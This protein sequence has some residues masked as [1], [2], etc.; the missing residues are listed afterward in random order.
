[1]NDAID[2][3]W[4]RAQF[5][6]FSVPVNADQSFFENAG[7]SFACRQT[8]DAL[9]TYYVETKVQPYAD[10]G[11]STRA[12]DE[13]DRSRLRWAASL[14]V[15]TNEV[16]F[17]P[18]TSMN[19][20]VLAD[21]FGQVMGP[22]DELI[23]TNQ[24]HEA[25]TGVF[26]RMA[27]RR[28]LTMHEWRTDPHT[29]LLD[30]DQLSSLLNSRTRLVTV[31]HASNIIGQENDIVGITELAH[32]A[33]AR[34]IV[35]G[36]SFVPHTIPNVSALG[37]DVYLFSMYKTYSVHQGLMVVRNGLLD[38]LP[39]QG[40]FFN[41][42]DASKRLSPAGPDHAQV[43]SS[44]AVLDYIGAFHREHGG[45]DDSPRDACAEASRRWRL[46]ENR[47]SAQLLALLDARDDVRVIGPTTVDGHFHRCP[48]ISFSPLA[49][50]PVDVARE[51]CKRGVQT[52]AGD[53]YAV[54][55]LDG[56]GIDP[57][58]GVV[59]LSS[60][61]YTSQ[62]DIDRALTALTEVLDQEVSNQ[63]VLG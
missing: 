10:Y 56:V 63:E 30:L 12:G 41:G 45:R 21:A 38:Q 58:R 6:A 43:A 15:S 51:L 23:V 25:N 26:R 17:G 31:P 48:T 34:V 27:E 13:M 28:G 20:F 11:T 8:I 53:F 59:R 52:S 42:N 54:R 19:T 40:H 37:A 33:G 5:P 50:E 1:M 55:V 7:G 60:V 32:A 18:S 47:L 2:L 9:S 49:Q 4:V 36:V 46:H 39:N 61:H 22:D 35:D 62:H 57:E 16:V 3:D 14:G 29:G 24:D 44:G